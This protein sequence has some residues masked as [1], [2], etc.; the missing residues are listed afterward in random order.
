M[1]IERP[2][3]RIPMLAIHLQREIYD[4]GFNPN[5]QTQLP[6]ILATS[7]KAAVGGKESPAE[8]PETATDEK[9]KVRSL[10]SAF[11]S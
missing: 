7:I 11:H 1:K 5:K 6:P 2:I 10:I 4:K 8:N 3:L 9:P